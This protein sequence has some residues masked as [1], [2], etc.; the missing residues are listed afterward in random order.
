MLFHVVASTWDWLTLWNCWPSTYHRNWFGLMLRSHSNRYV[1]KA[2]WQVLPGQAR[3]LPMPVNSL[4]GPPGATPQWSTPQTELIP[5]TFSMM[6]NSPT[7]G[8]LKVPRYGLPSAQN[9]GQYP[10]AAS[11]VT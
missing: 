1:W 3:W 11:P 4:H 6:S 5:L 7:A 9:A 10:S 2:D 8:Q